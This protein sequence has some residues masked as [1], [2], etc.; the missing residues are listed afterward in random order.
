MSSSNTT[1]ETAA[2]TPEKVAFDLTRFILNAGY[3]EA[4]SS[5][6]VLDLYVECLN[7]TKDRHKNSNTPKATFG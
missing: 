4:K 6:E 7:A 2:G 5:T 3:A 1:I